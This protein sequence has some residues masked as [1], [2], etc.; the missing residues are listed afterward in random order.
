MADY[1]SWYADRSCPETLE[2]ILGHTGDIT[3]NTDCPEVEEG[4]LCLTVESKRQAETKIKNKGDQDKIHAI[5]RRL[6]VR[7]YEIFLQSR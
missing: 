5:H 3:K 4:L 2:E 6:A 7:T 1:F